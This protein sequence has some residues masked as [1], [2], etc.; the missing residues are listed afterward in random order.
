[1]TRVRVAIVLLAVL[2]S[3]ALAQEAPST[4]KVLPGGPN[5][6]PRCGFRAQL[7]ERSGEGQA[8]QTEWDVRYYTIDA[9]VDFAALQLDGTVTAY[10]T[11]VAAV[12]SLV[13]DALDTL[14]PSAVTMPGQ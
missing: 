9:T 6:V 3:A 11:P 1:M 8:G 5:A 13:L 12:D 2:A 4:D 10:V 7:G 14:T